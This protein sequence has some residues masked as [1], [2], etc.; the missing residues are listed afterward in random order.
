MNA[1]SEMPDIVVPS[2][3]GTVITA[4][5]SEYPRARVQ[6]HLLLAHDFTNQLVDA[7]GALR[8][9][10]AEQK[11]GMQATIDQYERS[12]LAL[13]GGRA[14]GRRGGL[15][16]TTRDELRKV[17]VTVADYRCVTG[18][19][20]AAQALVNEV[21]DD[22][23]EGISQDIRTLLTQAFVRDERTGRINVDRLLQLRRV[24]LDH[25]K[26]PDA[27]RAIADS[28]DTRGS[29]THIRFYERESR[30][31]EWRQIPLQFSAL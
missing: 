3:E 14:S 10:M 15:S 5:G 20:V 7:A 24:N 9:L 23:T 28:I 8:D 21:L 6:P 4:S 25:P 1:L 30:D 31:K 11:A 22:L 19:V 17:D 12:V 16:I 26:W 18:A 29:K 27:Q 2:T 13:Y